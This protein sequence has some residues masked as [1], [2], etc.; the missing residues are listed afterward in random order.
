MKIIHLT[1]AG[2][3]AN[4]SSSDN[5]ASLA[6]DGIGLDITDQ[7]ENEHVHCAQNDIPTHLD[8]GI[9]IINAN[10]QCRTLSQHTVCSTQCENEKRIEFECECW[11]RIGI[12]TMFDIDS[13]QW[14]T[15]LDAPCSQTQSDINSDTLMMNDVSMSD[16]TVSPLYDIEVEYE[17]ESDDPISSITR[18]NPKIDERHPTKC[19]KLGKSWNCSNGNSKR[20]TFI[21]TS[22]VTHFPIV[23]HC[24]FNHVR[25]IQLINPKRVCAR[26][27]M[28]IRLANGK[29]KAKNVPKN[30]QRQQ[31]CRRQ[32]R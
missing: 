9:D 3:F 26:L 21:L 25:T 10:L 12:I 16:D 28:I 29:I 11:K 27:K 32:C 1:A 6:L 14:K 20:Y 23:D 5:F 4:A 7:Y 2:L 13:C 8:N 19:S 15:I 22:L 24:A 30:R 31:Q 18:A 17:S